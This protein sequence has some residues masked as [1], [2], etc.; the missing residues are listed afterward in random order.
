MRRFVSLVAAVLALVA[1]A[2][3]AIAA[4]ALTMTAR[5]LAGGHVRV[6]AWSAIEVD[7]ANDGPAVVG[8]LR[9]ASD[10]TSSSSYAALV[11]LPTGSRKRYVL[12]AQPSIFGRDLG[13]ALVSEGGTLATATVPITA[14]DPYQSVIGV[15]A[16]EPGIVAALCCLARPRVA[17]PAVVALAPEDC[18]RVEAWSGIDRLVWQDVDTSL[19]QP[20]QLA[21][22]RT[23]LGLGGRLVIL[24][25]TTGASTLGSLPDD[26]LRIGRRERS[27]HPDE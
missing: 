12:Y 25:G 23:W 19:L 18:P 3:S 13:V 5:P 6:G 14:H 24:G 4:D 27:M 26:L 15:V 9:L 17:T 2:P 10:A 8:E 16:E 21:A 7:V 1:M 11:D 20:D 22:L